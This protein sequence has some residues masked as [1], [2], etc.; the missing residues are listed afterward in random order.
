MNKKESDSLVSKPECELVLIILINSVL[1]LEFYTCSMQH[2]V[3]AREWLSDWSAIDFEMSDVEEC[4]MESSEGILIWSVS[5][6]SSLA[7]QH[8]IMHSFP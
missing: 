6:S 3:T 7:K 1:T 2:Y 5:S 4:K 8:F